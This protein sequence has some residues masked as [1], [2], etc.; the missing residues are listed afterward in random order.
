MCVKQTW[1]VRARTPWKRPGNERAKIPNKLLRRFAPDHRLASGAHIDRTTRA[2]YGQEGAH[3]YG[4]NR[5][6]R[7]HGRSS[8]TIRKRKERSEAMYPELSQS[9]TFACLVRVQCESA[10]AGNSPC[11]TCIETRV[12]MRE[13]KENRR[14]TSM[15]PLARSRRVCGW[16]SPRLGE[17]RVRLSDEKSMT[18]RV[19]SR[20]T[21]RTER[22]IQSR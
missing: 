13:Q 1:P 10:L 21:A 5:A 2:P 8:S 20:K 18:K 15:L 4:R 7:Q 3:I 11:I 6:R 22:M 9:R 19:H 17:S 16:S 14:V 12:Y